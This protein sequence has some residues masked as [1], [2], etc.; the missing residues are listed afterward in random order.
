MRAALVAPVLI[1]VVARPAFADESERYKPAVSTTETTSAAI[2]P[3]D[4][5]TEKPPPERVPIGNRIAVEPLVGFGTSN[6]NFGTGGRLGYTFSLPVYVGAAFLWHAGDDVERGTT[7]GISVTKTNYYY[8]ALETGYDIG[9]ARGLVMLRP[10]AGT[11]ILYT[12]KNVVLNASNTTNTDDQAMLYPGVTA[13]V[14][15]PDTPVFVGAD[16][17]LVIPLEQGKASY[18]VFVTVGL[19]R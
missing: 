15:V 13:H 12:R 7:S 14:N 10:Y 17:R 16:N 19:T 8:P 9:L 3:R 6:W 2:D 18:Q 1:V 4:L 11:A 5:V